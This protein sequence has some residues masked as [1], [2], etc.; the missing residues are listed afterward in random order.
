MQIGPILTFAS[1]VAR[2]LGSNTSFANI[3]SGLNLATLDILGASLTERTAAKLR[4]LGTLPPVVLRDNSN[5]QLLLPARSAN[6][7]SVSSGWDKAVAK[8]IQNGVDILCLVRVGAYSDLDFAELLD[9]HLQTGSRLTQAYSI[10]GSLNIALVDAARL[11]ESNGAYRKVLGNMMGEQRRFTYR[12]YINPLNTISDYY[13]L[14]RDGLFGRCGLRPMGEQMKEGV[15]L[16]DGARLD[17]TARVVAP[18]F[19]GA[20]ARIG[21]GCTVTAGSSIERN[22][23]I[24]C[25]SLIE[26]SCVLQD[27]YI[28]VALDIRGCVV[29]GRKV[30]HLGRNVELTFSDPRLVGTNLPASSLWGLG[31][32]HRHSLEAQ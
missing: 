20:G 5:N 19:I 15:W 13:E 7:D 23:E 21:P 26:D 31:I 12:G 16:G 28:G 22:C 9:F 25:G 30:F 10:D 1:D 29:A 6:G 32:A 14:A 4:G 18:V 24:D 17:S 3:R 27:T 11:R 8:Y 2:E